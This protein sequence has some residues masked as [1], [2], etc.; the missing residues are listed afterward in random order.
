MHHLLISLRPRATESNNQSNIWSQMRVDLACTDINYSDKMRFR[1]SIRPHNQRRWNVFFLMTWDVLFC[2]LAHQQKVNMITTQRATQSAL[3][4][5][6]EVKG[7][8][9]GRKSTAP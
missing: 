4:R 6:D 3:L 1:L 7:R 2:T 8:G 5:W 9:M